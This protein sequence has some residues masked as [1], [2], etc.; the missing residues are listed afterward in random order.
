MSN[1]VFWLC[2]HS[3]RPTLR[4]IRWVPL[5]ISP[6]G[7][8]RCRIMTARRLQLLPRFR[9][10][11]VYINIHSHCGDEVLRW[12][13]DVLF[14]STFI[15]TVVMKCSGGLEMF[16]LHQHSFT[17][18]WW[19]AQVDWRCFVYIN[20]HS[21]C[22]DEVLRWI[23]DVLF[24]STFIHTVVIKCSDGLEM[25]CLHQHSFTLWW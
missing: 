17:L 5:V 24:T 7:W 13:G 6:P 1:T 23:G 15:H 18:W 3:L 14:T 2:H 20:I 21:H 19:S 9:M 22:G 16:C 12:T 25:F 8:T 11:C 10:S 4:P